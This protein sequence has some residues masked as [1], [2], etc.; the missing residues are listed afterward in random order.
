MIYLILIGKHGP[1]FE[2]MEYSFQ[3]NE[4]PFLHNKILAKKKKTLLKSKIPVDLHFYQIMLY[5]IAVSSLIITSTQFAEPIKSLRL[6]S[7]AY[8]IN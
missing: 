6:G 8:S 5:S 1:G 7:V 3:Q 2:S 4:S